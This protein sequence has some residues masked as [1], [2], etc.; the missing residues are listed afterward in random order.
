MGKR[1]HQY[2]LGFMDDCNSHVADPKSQPP[3]EE[4]GRRR[5]DAPRRYFVRHPSP[6]RQQALCLT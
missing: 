2:R 5:R 3:L 4:E 6:L 1:S